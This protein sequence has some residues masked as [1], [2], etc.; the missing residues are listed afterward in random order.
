MCTP[1]ILAQTTTN[2]TQVEL[3]SWPCNQ[4]PATHT[5]QMNAG[6]RWGVKSKLPPTDVISFSLPWS[7]R[8]HGGVILG[9]KMADFLDK[10]T[11]VC[12]CMCFQKKIS[13]RLQ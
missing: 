5:V 9:E 1:P 6:L 12:G 13:P 11:E 2:K 10:F 4:I 3:V 7:D 8:P